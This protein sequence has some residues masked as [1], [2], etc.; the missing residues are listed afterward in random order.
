MIFT[1]V[2]LSYF[3]EIMLSPG[4][5]FRAAERGG[6]STACISCIVQFAHTKVMQFTTL[7]LC[8]YQ[9]HVQVRNSN[10]K[11]ILQ[12]LV[13]GYIQ[14]RSFVVQRS[15]QLKSMVE[16]KEL[17][18][19]RKWVYSRSLRMLTSAVTVQHLRKWKALQLQCKPSANCACAVL[20]NWWAGLFRGGLPLV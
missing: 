17:Y 5:P 2:P 10:S 19:S 3:L 4:N 11:I 12:Q 16:A 13:K 15:I 6:R 1:F 20:L 8:A 18:Y 9:A 14:C 7:K